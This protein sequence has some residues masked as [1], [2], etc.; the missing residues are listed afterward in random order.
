MDNDNSSTKDVS[1]CIGCSMKGKPEC[2]H[3]RDSLIEK[4][5]KYD[6]YVSSKS[7]VKE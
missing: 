1:D 3:I 2:D 5:T 4:G 7:I 6:C